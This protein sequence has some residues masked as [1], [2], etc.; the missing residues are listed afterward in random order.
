MKQQNLS[1][2]KRGSNNRKKAKIAVAKLH[3]KVANNRKEFLHQT[4][5][6]IVKTSAL[7]AVEKLNIKNMSAEGGAY[8]KGLNR[9]ILSAAPGMFHQMLKYKA[10]E[11][12][13]EWIEIPTREVKPSQTCHACGRQEKKPLAQRKHDC[14]CGAQCTRDENAAR[15][16]LNW[17]LSGNASGQELAGCGELALV[18]SVKHETPSIDALA[19]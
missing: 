13:I 1:R 11:A 5:A 9:E 17:A 6:R 10:E 15:V 8:K 12:G 19:A 7:I 2:K 4:T 14:G 16:I 18:G 3:A